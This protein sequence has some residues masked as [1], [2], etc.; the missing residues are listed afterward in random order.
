MAESDV[1]APVD[2]AIND[3]HPDY[4]ALVLVASGL[5]NGP[6]GTYS[7]ARLAAAEE[8]LRSSGLGR[9]TNHPRTASWRAAFS[10]CAAKPSRYPSSAEALITRVLKGQ[11][12]PRVNA[13]V[14]LYNAVSVRQ[15]V[16]VG[17][18]DADRLEG[19]LRL[20]LAAGG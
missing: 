14:D 8:E 9:A 2:P 1:E 10:A 4:V 12:L 17:G 11:P 7:E 15:L 19:A 18:E 16:P 13:L 3:R 5:E 6:A 20:T